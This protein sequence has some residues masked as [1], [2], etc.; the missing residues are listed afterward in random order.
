MLIDFLEAADATPLTKRF[1]HQMDGS[2]DVSPYPFV[3][4]F[5][6][7]REDISSIEELF[8]ALVRHSASQ[9]CMLKGL[10]EQPLVDA[11]RAGQM[12][13][14]HPTDWL[15]LDLDFSEGW[16]SIDDFLIEIEP[17]WGDVSYIYQQSASAGITKP[18]GLRGHVWVMLDRP[19]FPETLKQWLKDVNLTTGM[20]NA[21][22]RLSANARALIWPLDITT[23]QNDKLIYIANPV[24]DGLV[25]PIKDRWHL[26]KKARDTGN[27]GGY[28]SMAAIDADHARTI[29]GL[30]AEQGYD[31]SRTK[32]K[33]IKGNKL[34]VNPE[35][36]EITGMKSARGFTYLN[37]N[38]GDSW[39]YY[40]PNDDPTIVWNFKGEAPFYLEDI[41]PDIFAQAIEDLRAK[42]YGHIRPLIFRDRK[43]DAYYNATYDD[44]TNLIET[45]AQ[46]SSKDKLRDFAT[47]YMSH[48]PDPIPDYDLVFDPQL[49]AGIDLDSGVVN[50]YRPSKYITKGPKLP[51]V[52]TVPPTIGRILDS[53][54]VT[55]EVQ[56]RFLNWL[57]F[58][59]QTRSKTETAWIFHGVPGT[60]KGILLNKII[61][62]LLGPNYVTQWTIGNLLDK[63]DSQLDTTCLLWI[64]EFYL[65]SGNSQ[66][67]MAINK[68]KAIITEHELSSRAMRQNAVTTRNFANVIIATNHPDPM[69][70]SENDRRIN[71]APAQEN[72]LLITN[73]EIDTIDEELKD[74]AGF[75][76]HYEVNAAKVRD[77]LHGEA[78]DTMIAAAQSSTDAFFANLRLGNLSWFA[79]YLLENPDTHM[80]FEHQHAALILRGWVLQ[81]IE[82]HKTYKPTPI[83]MTRDEVRRLYCTLTH[84]TIAPTKFSRMC[85]IQR[86][87]M[88][89]GRDYDGNPTMVFQTNVVADLELLHAMSAR[90]MPTKPKLVQNGD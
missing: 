2:I 12:K 58:I 71:V 19:I 64:D 73:A 53:I 76:Q 68:L 88:K 40:F 51:V 56:E 8:D 66:S 24:C 75:L 7:Y 79:D 20:L 23:C 22:I 69:P 28:R 62:P 21:Q 43:R 6:S 61:R 35:P 72:K 34:I 54:C 3:K 47:L 90:L 57:A 89:K 87:T 70:I 80:I 4:N 81:A 59:F 14:N 32:H 26:V 15:L 36:C 39:A 27:I 55:E 63:F 67:T 78:R 9:H 30:R 60:G 13:K 45:I 33:T 82:N 77:I 83:K 11:S 52:K 5:N 17:S 65:P 18:E 84:T 1:A 50:V 25:D 74:F 44:R 37:L 49:L 16:N 38:G 10:L 85:T 41:A 42:T 86:T 48:L 29:A 46:C 31:N